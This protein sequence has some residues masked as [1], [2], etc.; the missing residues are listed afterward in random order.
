MVHGSGE[1]VR[2]S[3]ASSMY[4]GYDL[5]GPG[6]YEHVTAESGSACTREARYSRGSGVDE[7]LAMSRSGS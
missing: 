7:P 5:N 1:R 4:Y 3:S 6:G 2:V